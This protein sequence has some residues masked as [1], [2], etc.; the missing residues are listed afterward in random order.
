MPTKIQTHLRSIA[1]PAVAKIAQSFFKTG[2]GQYG[3]GDIFL[4]IKVPT[5][6]ALIKSYRGTPLKMIDALIKSKFHEERLFAL[7]LLI[8]FYQRGDEHAQ[9]QAYE[10]YLAHTAH[11]NNWDLVDVSAPHI[12]G[13]F[14]A[15]KP[16]D[17]LYHLLK[18]NSLWE[19]RIAIIA[20]F[21]FI[22]QND[23]NDTLKIAEHL[24]SDQHDLMHKAVGWMLREVG[25]RDQAAL[26]RFLRHHC[27][28]MPRTALRYAIE[29]LPEPL[30]LNY[31]RPCKEIGIGSTTLNV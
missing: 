2:P 21:H 3:E 15:D 28:V 14:L 9:Q 19:R 6:R 22:R 25:K 7:L 23:F 8:D 26:E 20:T 5:L 30:R 18:S 4:G 29:R 24:L 11:I 1:D 17:T 13:N 27:P 16:R 12:V 10:L 31:L